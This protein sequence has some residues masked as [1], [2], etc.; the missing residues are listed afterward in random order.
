MSLLLDIHVALWAVSGNDTIGDDFR[1]RLRHDP[2]IFLSS[3]VNG[4]VVLTARAR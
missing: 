3:L 1:N 2:D 4:G